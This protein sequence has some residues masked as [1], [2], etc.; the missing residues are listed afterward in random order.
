[1]QYTLIIQ[2]MEAFNLYNEIKQEYENLLPGK[3]AMLVIFH[4]YQRIENKEIGKV[5]SEND[6]IKSI[7]HVRRNAINTEQNIQFYQTIRSL[8]KFF[9]WR[10]EEKGL[11]SFRSYAEQLC[12]EIEKVLSDTFK[13]TEI[14]EDFKYILNKLDEEP[15]DKWYNYIF[16][17]Y[18]RKV[19]AQT[20]VL[21]RKV[22][23]A[24]AQFRNEINQNTDYNISSLKK[25]IEILSGLG[26]Q[27]RELNTAFRSSRQIE[28]WMLNFQKEKKGTTYFQEST[29]VIKYFRDIRNKLQII[30]RKIDSIKP[31]LDEYINNISQ[32]DFYRKFKLL[33]KY[34]L[35]NSTLNRSVEVCLPD[36]ISN[37]CILPDKIQKF[38]IIKENWTPG[39]TSSRGTKVHIP[40][41]DKEAALRELK[42]C[43]EKA[44]AS[45]RIKLY[46]DQLEK[47]L[48]ARK[49]VD[50]SNYFFEVM[51][52]EKG[53]AN[54]A[55]RFATYAM[56]KYFKSK[57]HQIEI[58]KEKINH[59]SYP[60][61]AVWKTTIYKHQ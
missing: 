33:L 39:Q 47:Q 43:N 2:A 11:Y 23:K 6:I 58:R 34:T 57:T 55:A 36:N 12:A 56:E 13:P 52:K 21:D 3:N 32:Q 50:F 10:D 59:P 28:E 42:K 29:D 25:I 35:E 18:R 31:K 49:E 8:Q 26:T 7:K 1:M 41:T 61:I 30:G 40:L 17:N 38:F 4:L 22:A 37:E 9:L 44:A 27:T 53:D 5:F 20:S 48:N 15:F 51:H 14:E 46:L 45:K 24:I 54:I 16:E 19:N 60:K